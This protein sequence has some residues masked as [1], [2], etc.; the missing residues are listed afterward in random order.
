[1]EAVATVKAY[2]E[3]YGISY[4]SANVFRRLE[5]H[6]SDRG[7]MDIKSAA[8]ILLISRNALYRRIRHGDVFA[9]KRYGVLNMAVADVLKL[10]QSRHK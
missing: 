2:S 9:E 4:G 1:M 7:Y 6:P 10:A 8:R 5:I 3:I